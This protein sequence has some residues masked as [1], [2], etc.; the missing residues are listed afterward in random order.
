MICKHCKAVF[1]PPKKSRMERLHVRSMIE[2]VRVSAVLESKMES[3][4][5][6]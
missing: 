1:T 5:V 4:T 2:A 3:L 6:S